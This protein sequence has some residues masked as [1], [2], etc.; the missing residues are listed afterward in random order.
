MAVL[1]DEKQT[2]VWAI[3]I[4]GMS[5][6]RASLAC[7][8]CIYL[9]CHRR[10]QK[11]F[12]GNHALQLSKRPLGI[13]SI[14]FPL[15]LRSFLALLAFGSLSDICQVFQTDQAMG[16]PINDALR[17]HM[18]GVLRSPVSLVLLSPPNGG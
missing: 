10:L 14:S 4:T 15:L 16:V 11:S 6:H 7:I 8:V 13:G 17:D 18:V 3:S 2:L 12:V 9:D 1:A 5:T